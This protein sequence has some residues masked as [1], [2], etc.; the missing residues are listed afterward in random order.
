MSFLTQD[1]CYS[2]SYHIY[3]QGKEKKR[4][5]LHQPESKLSQLAFTPPRPELSAADLGKGVPV[6]KPLWWGRTREKLAGMSY[7]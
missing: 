5:G 2:S 3:M 7:A 6:S 4:E 1:C